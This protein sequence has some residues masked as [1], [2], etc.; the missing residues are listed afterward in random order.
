MIKISTRELIKFEIDS[1]PDEVLLEIQKYIVLQKSY[2]G[3]Y[4][5][6]TDYLR[7]IPGMEE[8]IIEGLNTPISEC[9]D[10]LE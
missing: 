1:L 10:S 5:N 6:D 3:M 8:S 9:F 4:D 7:S 2:M